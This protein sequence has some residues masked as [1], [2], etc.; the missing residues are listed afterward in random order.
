MYADVIPIT[1]VT[2]DS[3]RGLEGSI[4]VASFLYFTWSGKIECERLGM[5]II[6]PRQ[7]LTK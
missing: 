6:I 5:C 2:E 1:T 3:R 4:M 7:P